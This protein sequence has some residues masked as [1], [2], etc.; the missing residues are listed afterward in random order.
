VKKHEGI[1]N[2]TKFDKIFIIYYIL[3]FNKSI[4]GF[5]IFHGYHNKFKWLITMT[6]PSLK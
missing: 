6:F 4:S 2:N 1:Y 3:L 5:M